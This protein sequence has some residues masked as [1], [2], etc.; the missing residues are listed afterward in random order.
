MIASSF[1]GIGTDAMVSVHSHVL[2]TNKLGAL[3]DH[4]PQ[5]TA[6]KDIA[7]GLIDAWKAYKN[8]NAI[9]VFVIAEKEQNIFDQRALEF[10]INELDADVSIY[11][12]TLTD[13]RTAR[14]DERDR[15]FMYVFF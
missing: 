1:I 11:R 9:L 7:T 6:L 12:F 10:K 13:F 14:I 3:L 4:L 2:R 5:N 8:P 15:L